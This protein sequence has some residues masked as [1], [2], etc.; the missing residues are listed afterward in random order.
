MAFLVYHSISDNSHL[1]SCSHLR[2]EVIGRLKSDSEYQDV[3]HMIDLL[4]LKTNLVRLLI[5]DQQYDS[6]LS[7]QEASER[8]LQTPQMTGIFALMMDSAVTSKLAHNYQVEHSATQLIEYL[9]TNTSLSTLEGCC[10][11]LLRVAEYILQKDEA[12]LSVSFAVTME[13]M[14]RERFME[15][16]MVLAAIVKT[17]EPHQRL[18][19]RL[20]QREY[21]LVTAELTKCCNFLGLEVEG[22]EHASRALNLLNCGA[23]QAQISSMQ[24]ILADSLICQ[25]KYDQAENILKSVLAGTGLSAYVKIA[26]I[27]RLNK[28]RRRLDTLTEAGLPLALALEELPMLRQSLTIDAWNEILDELSSSQCYLEQRN[29]NNNARVT[30][31]MK[32]VAIL[33]GSQISEGETDWR[34]LRLHDKV[35]NGQTYRERITLKHL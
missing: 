31:T 23:T 12:D 2:P 11:V 1:D 22:E 6:H 8:C 3:H 21:L 19:Q 18:H 35:Y 25:R 13:L 20:H 28:I 32:V 16:R 34:L 5:Y 17:L 4:E 10:C 27:L 33:V 24:I 30:Q 26:A 15:A 14:R 9:G 7:M 29:Y